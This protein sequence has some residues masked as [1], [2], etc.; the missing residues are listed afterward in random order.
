MLGEREYGVL[1]TDRRMIFV[2]ERTSRVGIA[3]GLGGAVGAVLASEMA[4]KR[5]F[6]YA[7][8]DPDALA[9]LD[10]TIVVP[11]LSVRGVR[12]RRSFNGVSYAM[13]IE[14]ASGDGKVKKLNCMLSAPDELMNQRKSDGAKFKVI[15]YEYAKKAQEAFKLALPVGAREESEWLK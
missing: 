4:T 14:Y 12:V 6:V 2:L 5:E 15:L 1:L 13:H 9:K 10:G 3:A 7:D 11:D 8:A